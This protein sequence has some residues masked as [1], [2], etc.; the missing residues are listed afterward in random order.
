MD[1]NVSGK[2]REIWRE[3][4]G[5]MGTQTAWQNGANIGSKIGA[6]IDIHKLV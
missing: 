4:R 5:E 1:V 2:K 6:K 3:N